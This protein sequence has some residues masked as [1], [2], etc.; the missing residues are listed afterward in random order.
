MCWNVWNKVSLFY[1]V[2]YQHKPTCRKRFSI[3]FKKCEFSYSVLVVSDLPRFKN[4]IAFDIG[5]KYQVRLDWTFCRPDLT[6]PTWL[7]RTQPNQITPS[8]SGSH[9]RMVPTLS[10]E[11]LFDL[12]AIIN[13]QILKCVWVFEYCA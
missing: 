9:T 10:Y 7:L 3:R 5:H 13:L 11:Y 2:D 1:K 6:N 8:Y 12:N 4:I